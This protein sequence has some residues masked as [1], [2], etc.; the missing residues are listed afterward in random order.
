MSKKARRRPSWKNKY[1][2]VFTKEIYQETQVIYGMDIDFEQ[3]DR[4][5]QNE[6]NREVLANVKLTG[7]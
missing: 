7:S 6:I 2:V 4:E 3:L 1:R 5:I